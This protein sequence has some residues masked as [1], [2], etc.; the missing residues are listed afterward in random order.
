MSERSNALMNRYLQRE[1][2][3]QHPTPTRSPV[4]EGTFKGMITARGT[5]LLEQLA[6]DRAR[7][8][9][10]ADVETDGG[11]LTDDQFRKWAARFL[12]S[13]KGVELV[14]VVSIPSVDALVPEL[15][16]FQSVG[17]EAAHRVV[18]MFFEQR[19][20]ARVKAER[21][22]AEAELRQAQ[23]EAEAAEIAEA[24]DYE[25]EEITLTNEEKER[26]ARAMIAGGLS[27]RKVAKDLGIPRSTLRHWLERGGGP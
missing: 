11:A 2:E 22:I 27:Q 20:R 23:E 19:A 6:K 5:H 12:D 21:E 24:G 17:L 18:D 26:A 8:T 9:E 14:Q 16:P 15:I 3:R 13:Q 25:K 7:L 1:M 10:P 4:S